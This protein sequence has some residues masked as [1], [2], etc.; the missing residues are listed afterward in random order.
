MSTDTKINE[1]DHFNEWSRKYDRSWIQ[2]YARPIHQDMLDA[3]SGL[4]AAPQTILD[5]GCGTGQLLMKAAAR[6]PSA[7]CI[8]VDPS[9]GMVAIAQSQARGATIHLGNAESVPVE[10][11][12]ADIVFS[13]IS[14]H[15]WSDQSKGLRE[16]ARVLRPHGC[17]CLA[18][19]TMPHWL[20]GI[21]R[22]VNIKEPSDMIRLFTEAGF[23]VTLQRRT[24]T[25]FA[26]LTL[27]VKDSG[28]IV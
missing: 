26:L 27:G 1:I 8:G 12:S 9:P 7:R 22:H 6:W 24:F 19:L 18:D 28:R 10:S 2:H 21:I 11:S 23:R 17:L 5:V 16:I 4:V 15:H 25:R 20:A 14:F 3:A 13:S